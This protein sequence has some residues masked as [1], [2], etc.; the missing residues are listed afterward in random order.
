[1][2]WTTTGASVV[3]ITPGVGPVTPNGSTQVSPTTTTTYTLTASTSDGKSVS[4][5]VTVTVSTGQVPQVVTFVANPQNIDAGQSTKLCW[6]VTGAISISITPDV[7]SNLAANDCATVSPTQTT[8]YTLT[9]TNAAGTIQ[10]NTTVNVG[11]VRILSFTS[12]PVFSQASGSP[13][14]LSWKTEN[15]TS[16]VLVGNDIS[17]QTLPAN[18]TFVIHPVSNSTY[19]LTAYGP[20]GQTVSVTI[21]VFVR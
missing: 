3:T 20:G 21:S 11:Q 9:A 1:L 8:T 10:A 19:T 4:A 15:A 14:T 7:G 12:D 2:S 17:P 18:G 6:Q 5:P 13:V 16:V